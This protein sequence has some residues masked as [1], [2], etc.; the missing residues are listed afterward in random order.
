MKYDVYSVY[1]PFMV[2]DYDVYV[3]GFPWKYHVSTLAHIR[4]V[5]QGNK[6]RKHHGKFTFWKHSSESVGCYK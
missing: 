3:L 5:G 2:Y 6:W 1:F 4:K